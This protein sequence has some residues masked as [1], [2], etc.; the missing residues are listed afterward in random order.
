MTDFVIGFIMLIKQKSNF[1]KLILVIVNQIAKIVYYK[2]VKVMI[3]IFG[4]AKVIFN[5]VAWY[6]D[7]SNTI[8]SN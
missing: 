6:Y 8:I 7:I 1:F 4:R 2:L 3:N 5:I